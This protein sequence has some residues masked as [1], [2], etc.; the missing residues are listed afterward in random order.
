MFQAAH[1]KNLSHVTFIHHLLANTSLD[2]HLKW[3]VYIMEYSKTH[4]HTHTKSH[5][6]TI[7]MTTQC[8]THL[9]VVLHLRHPGWVH[10]GSGGRRHQLLQE[11]P[12]VE[13]AAVTE[14]SLHDLA[15]GGRGL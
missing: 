14:G 7:T 6:D 15:L 11:L 4:T 13:A 10:V 3:Y 8:S 5:N 1:L 12:V 9:L 2:D